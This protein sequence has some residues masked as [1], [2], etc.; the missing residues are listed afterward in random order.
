MKWPGR[1]FKCDGNSSGPVTWP[2]GLPFG[3]GCLGNP[4]SYPKPNPSVSWSLFAF[5]VAK[6]YAHVAN[7]PWHD[8]ILLRPA[9]PNARRSHT[10]R[11]AI[12]LGIG[13]FERPRPG[14]RLPQCDWG[15]SLL[16]ATK[17][18]RLKGMV[19]SLGVCSENNSNHCKIRGSAHRILQTTMFCQ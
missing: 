15:F 12:V 17:R 6:L 16:E 4:S 14:G 19:F 8:A 1:L 3:F 7:K 13:E 9:F 2:P 10:D 18:L 11:S 5:R